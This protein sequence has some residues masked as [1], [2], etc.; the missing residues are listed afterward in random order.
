M[1][2]LYEVPSPFEFKPVSYPEYIYIEQAPEIEILNVLSVKS[3]TVTLKEI[4]HTLVSKKSYFVQKPKHKISQ[5]PTIT[6]LPP[7]DDTTLENI[8]FAEPFQTL[9]S[10]HVDY[11][12]ES[13]RLSHTYFKNYHTSVPL[14][15]YCP[16]PLLALF[17]TLAFI[18]LHFLFYGLFLH[19]S[20]LYLT[21]LWCRKTFFQILIPA[22]R[23]VILKC[24]TSRL[25]YTAVCD[26][27]SQCDISKGLYC[28]ENTGTCNCPV[29]STKTF[30]DCE[31][32][33]Y[34]DYDLDKCGEFKWQKNHYF[35]H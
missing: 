29:A 30:C 31:L 1:K 16:L 20:K 15:N 18:L 34:W 8:A 24:N 10:P 21:F 25:R 27:T 11:M 2:R 13:R 35:N 3:Q 17:L 19:T 28:P 33:H 9:E 32:D 23:E 5:S 4:P 6:E 7:P 26:D 22:N 12:S 14:R